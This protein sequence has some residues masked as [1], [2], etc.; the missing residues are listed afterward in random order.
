M[1][2]PSYRQLD[3]P[4]AT[5]TARYI[6]REVSLQ[7]PTGL[8]VKT[9]QYPRKWE[10]YFPS[11]EEGKVL[12]TQYLS[13]VDPLVHIIHKPSF[14]LELHNCLFSP[15]HV[16]PVPSFKALLLAMYLAAALSLCPV[17]CQ[18]QLVIDKNK[19]VGKLEIA[20]EKALAD[21]NYVGSHKVQ[22]LQAFTMYM[23]WITS[24]L[25]FE[26]HTV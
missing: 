20:T 6:Q 4:Y 8:L 26:A 12:Y 21:A 14:E 22:T 7:P 5:P 9:S 3:D 2:V 17:E 16:A 15:P 11:L 1:A 19:L 25:R 24:R 18:I 13:A 10:N 23:V